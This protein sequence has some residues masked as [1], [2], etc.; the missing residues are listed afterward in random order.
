MSLFIS[1]L[2][3]RFVWDTSIKKVKSGIILGVMYSKDN[4]RKDVEY[5]LISQVKPERCDDIIL[6]RSLSSTGPTPI[7]GIDRSRIAWRST[8]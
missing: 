1:I 5:L 6:I 8:R 2:F 4:K 7:N 3:L